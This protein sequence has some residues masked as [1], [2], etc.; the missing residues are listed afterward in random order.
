MFLEIQYRQESVCI[1]LVA[2]DFD[3]RTEGRLREDEIG[4]GRQIEEL[5]VDIK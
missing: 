3:S 1:G 4:E 5:S 2:I